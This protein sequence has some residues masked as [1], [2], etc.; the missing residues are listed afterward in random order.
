TAERASLKIYD[1][2]GRVLK[3]VEGDFA[4]GYN[5]VSINRSELSGSGILYYELSTSKETAT[6]KMLL[7]D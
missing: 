2:A 4:K 1:V 3:S 5:E 7:I 6:K